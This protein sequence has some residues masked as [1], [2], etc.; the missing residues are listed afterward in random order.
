MDSFLV[1]YCEIGL[2]GPY[3]KDQG[4]L[5]LASVKIAPY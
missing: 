2:A 5:L 1:G 3:L 4:V